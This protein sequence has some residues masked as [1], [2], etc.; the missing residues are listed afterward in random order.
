[1]FLGCLDVLKR[2]ESALES[3]KNF[4]K[5][6][7]RNGVIENWN[8]VDMHINN[9]YYRLED[10]VEPWKSGV[11]KEV[12]RIW[13]KVVEE[14]IATSPKTNGNSDKQTVGTILESRDEASDDF[15]LPK[16]VS[17]SVKSFNP[18]E[19][20]LDLP[21]LRHQTSSDST[22]NLN[23]YFKN[24]TNGMASDGP[25][26]SPFAASMASLTSPSPGEPGSANA[27]NMSL[28]SMIQNTKSTETNGIS[29]V[30]QWIIVF[31][32]YFVCFKC[33][34]SFLFFFFFQ[35]NFLCSFISTQIYFVY[36]F[37]YLFKTYS[38]CI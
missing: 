33:Y 24:G 3:A 11:I 25:L 19:D 32:L 18:N 8:D 9:V 22:F 27:S 26:M 6:G 13:P 21:Q 15:K 20:N 38:R 29:Q 5:S 17:E 34:L 36:V 10:V 30:R 12:Y 31:C 16:S 1:M 37:I 7:L 2:F 4:K 23:E 14:F 28:L 35:C